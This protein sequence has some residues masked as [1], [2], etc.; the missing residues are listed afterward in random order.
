MKIDDEELI[1]HVTQEACSA[2]GLVTREILTKDKG[3]GY[4]TLTADGQTVGLVV[5][6][7]SPEHAERL[8]EYVKGLGG[9]SSS[10]VS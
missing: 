9:H 3:V 1:E 2:A 5:V 10:E 4:G 8:I 7:F 6:T